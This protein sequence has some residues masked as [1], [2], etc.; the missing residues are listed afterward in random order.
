MRMVTAYRRDEMPGIGS[1][2][3]Y[4]R[5]HFEALRLGEA[6]KELALLVT[7]I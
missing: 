1:Q 6:R 2:Q 5:P 7:G 4:P 3:E